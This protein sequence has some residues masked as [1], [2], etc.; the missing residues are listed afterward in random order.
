MVGRM[1]SDS[2]RITERF[3]GTWAGTGYRQTGS[4]SDTGIGTCTGTQ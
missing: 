3:T 1:E 2:Q 4:G